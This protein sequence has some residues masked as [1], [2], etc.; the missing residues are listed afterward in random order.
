M[1]SVRHEQRGDEDA[2]HAVNE[3]AFGQPTGANIVGSLRRQ[4]SDRLSLLVVSGRQIVGHILFAPVVVQTAHE[5]HR[6]MGLAP[7]AAVPEHQ[8]QGIGTKL[9]QVGLEIL[10]IEGCPFV[11]LVGHPEYY[12]R[13]GFVPAS[14]HGIVCQWEGIP[15]EAFMVMILD[16]KT[17]A[18]VSGTA[19]YR[20]EFDQAMREPNQALEAI[21]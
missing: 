4:C 18:A 16:E 5:T 2:I 15:D 12:P 19:R 13:F 7:M 10:R 3:K 6:G 8:R 20:P 11:I 21:F 14:K 1:I 17:M 9:V